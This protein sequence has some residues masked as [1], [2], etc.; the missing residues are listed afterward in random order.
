MATL[1][2]ALSSV[3]NIQLLLKYG[4]EPQAKN[5]MDKELSTLKSNII[6]VIFLHQIY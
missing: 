3:P 5:L 2:T 4:E 1:F 6:H